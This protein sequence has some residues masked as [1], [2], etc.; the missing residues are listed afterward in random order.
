MGEGDAGEPFETWQFDE[1]FV[2]GAAISEATAEE[3]IE[4]L[5]RIDADHDRLRTQQELEGR[6]ARSDRKR[7]RRW[8]R[9]STLLIVA[10]T[11]VIGIYTVKDGL[12]SDE[13]AQQ[14]FGGGSGDVVGG[15]TAY[16]LPAAPADEEDQPLGTPP[17]AP[18]GGGGAHKFLYTQPDG[19]TPVA[20]DPCQPIHY[21]VN[22]ATAP[23]ETGAELL[24]AAIANV[25]GATGLQ[26]VSDGS[27]QELP[28]LDRDPVQV[29]RYGDRWAPVLIAWSDPQ[30][31]PDLAGNVLGTAGSSW[32]ESPEGDGLFVTGLVVLDGAEILDVARQTDDEALV[33][34]TL[35]HELGHLVGLD[36][37][38]D[39]TQ[40]MNPYVVPG[41]DHF[42]A[43]DL[44]GLAAL[45]RGECFAGI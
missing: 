5:R 2:R 20:Y 21:V 12:F 6:S 34:A 3:R 45:G 41:V 26:F 44:A 13:A 1:E 25:S 42:A 37:V 29:E 27:T 24:D 7:R 8:P 30:Q 23:T 38:E 39:E 9:L 28:S 31:W 43:G 36:H 17:V 18:G 16:D 19:S 11:L 33:V 14:F 32:I 15:E 22:W 4:R 35:I 10:F 40:I